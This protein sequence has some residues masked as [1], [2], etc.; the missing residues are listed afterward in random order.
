MIDGF[1]KALVSEFRMHGSR[2]AWWSTEQAE[3]VHTAIAAAF[4]N[5]VCW[6]THKLPGTCDIVVVLSW[7][8]LQEIK[9][10]VTMVKPSGILI[11]ISVHRPQGITLNIP[12]MKR[13]A[14]RHHNEGQNLTAS[15]FYKMD[16]F[17][18]ALES[19][20]LGLALDALCESDAK[21][22]SALRAT[23]SGNSIQISHSRVSQM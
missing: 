1:T 16:D 15:V 2:T 8:S 11:W 18:R 10:A 13:I 19:K 14:V 21:M 12:D 7:M 5:K 23:G 9:A 4:R 3:I 17:D 22:R 20:Y 6:I